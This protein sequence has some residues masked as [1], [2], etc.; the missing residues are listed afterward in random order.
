MEP[1]RLGV[2]IDHVATIRNARGGHH[3]D[4][5]KAAKLAAAAGADGITAHL[6]EDRRHISDHDI[7]RLSSEIDLPL[8]LEMAATEEMLEIALRHAPNAACI[9]PEHRQEL[10]TEGGL[11]AHGGAGHL[12]PYIS[13]L[14][15]KGIRVSLFLDPNPRQLEAA[16]D[17]GA[18]I[19]ELH[20]GR[21]CDTGAADRLQELERIRDCAALGRQLGLEMHAGHGLGFETVG[22]VAAIPEIVELNIGHFLIGEAV[23]TGLEAAIRRMRSEM[24]QAR[25]LISGVKS[26]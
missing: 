16:K 14:R 22:A 24:D 12:S 2:N 1:L 20:T 9:V 3:P 13:R 7:R 8:N 6:R 25:A 10:T 23:F 18:D 26:A 17:L 11:D 15:E 5:V 21:Y 19:V 4:P